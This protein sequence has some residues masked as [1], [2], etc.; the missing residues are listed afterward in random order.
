MGGGLMQLVAYSAQDVYLTGNPQITF[1]KVVYRRHTNFAM[2]SIEQ[3]FNGTTDFVGTVS[4]TIS[5]NGDLIHNCILEVTVPEL[6]SEPSAIK[7]NDG[8][9]PQPNDLKDA[10]GNSQFPVTLLNSSG[11][12]VT[13]EDVVDQASAAWG[14]TNDDVENNARNAV[15]CAI[16]RG[17]ARWVKWLGHFLIKSVEVEIGGQ[18]IDRHYGHWLQVWRVI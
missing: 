6:C 12:V 2:E 18:K 17:H 4:V 13:D 3:T 10:G 1:F 14:L 11:G 15:Q 7:Q 9:V 8:A 5:R 16:N